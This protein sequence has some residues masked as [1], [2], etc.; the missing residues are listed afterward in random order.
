MQLFNRATGDINP[1]VARAWQKYDIAAILRRNWTRLGPK[2]N[3]KI[4][5]YVGTADD[6]FLDQP[7]H[8]LE[9]TLRELGGKASFNFLPGRTHENVYDDGVAERIWAEMQETTR[10]KKK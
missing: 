1:D 6:Y 7:A 8:L 9:Q 2:L 5:L 4:H 10:P 3:G